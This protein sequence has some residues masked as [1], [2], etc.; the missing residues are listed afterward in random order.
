MRANTL[1]ALMDSGVVTINGWISGNSPYLAEVLSYSGLDSVT[2]DLQ[3]GMFGLDAAVSLIQAVSSGP[4]IPL[5]RCSELNPAQIGKLLDAGAYGIICPSVDTVEHATALVAACNYPPQGTR[6]FG[7]SRGLLY[8]GPDYV[9]EA[10]STILVLA[11]IESATALANLEAIVA[12]PGL[13]G[14]YVGPNDLALSLGE[15]PGQWPLSPRMLDAV[16]RVVTAAHSV[17]L[18]A[19]I[20]CGTGAI[21]RDCA[22]LGYDL[23]TPANDA[24]IIRQSVAERIALIRGAASAGGNT[25]GY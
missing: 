1:T 9:A 2:I 17:G 6:S 12:V 16:K 11:M 21:A 22:A 13:S 18:K 5:A 25:G 4:A 23:V 3:H 14:V 15:T 8:G 20:F 24:G 7:P 19:G 10:G